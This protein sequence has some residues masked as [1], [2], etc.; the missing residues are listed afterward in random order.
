MKRSFIL[1]CIAFLVLGNVVFAE[2]APLINFS[3]LTQDYPAQ[4]STE[5]ERTLMD[6]STVAGNSFDEEALSQMKTSLAIPNWDIELAS[7]SQTIEN[8]TNSF[9][10]PAPVSGDS[11]FFAGETVMGIRIHFPTQPFN[12]W[13]MISPPFDIPAFADRTVIEQDEEGNDVLVPASVSEEGDGFYGEDTLQPLEEGETGDGSKF[14]NFGVVKNVGVLRS[15]SANIYGQNFPH[16]MSIIIENQNH[17]RREIPLGQLTFDGWQERGWVNPNYIEDVRNRELS[18]QP[19]Y[20]NATP[21]VKLVG[22]LIY[23]D[24][25]QTG[26]DFIS[27]IGNITVTY[28][29][30]VLD[31]ESDIQHEAIW[32][33]VSD[34]ERERRNSELERLGERQVLQYLERQRMHQDEGQGAQANQDTE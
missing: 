11:Q 16:T 7:S 12:S 13:A 3:E 29:Q 32:G 4:G 28:D 30:A 6:F 10:R 2:E 31:L 9:V 24:A 26:G 25:S 20:P 14:D 5:N 34:R 1:L 17:E 27:Y 19:L 22:I 23:R 15:V 8:M 21:F 18:R 33:I